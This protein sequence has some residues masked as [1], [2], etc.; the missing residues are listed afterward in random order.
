MANMPTQRQIR[1][2]I[3]QLALSRGEWAGMPRPMEGMRMVIH[4][5][6]PYAAQLS[7]T[8]M[9]AKNLRTCSDSDI[10]D[11]TQLRNSWSSYRDGRMLHIRRDSNGYWFTHGERQ[12]SAT[13]LIETLGASRAWDPEAE[14]RAIDKLRSLVR[15]YTFERYFMTGSFLE[16]S[17]RSK[18]TYIFRRLRPTVVLSSNGKQGRTQDG[19]RILC[20]LCLHP[21]GYYD[22]T[23]AG[24]LVPTDDVIAHLLLMRSDEALYWRQA[25]QIPP[26]APEAGL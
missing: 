23:W 8:F 6:Y 21:V 22:G 26:F 11:T 10:D 7:R 2:R 4:K 20:C 3:G 14:Q 5:S 12:N 19:M 13:I 16:S 15:T 1:E 24:A 18:L 17:P 9:P 25:N